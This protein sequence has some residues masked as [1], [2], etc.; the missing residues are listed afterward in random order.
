SPSPY[1]VDDP[2]QTEWRGR[3]LFGSYMVD[4]EGVPAKPPK[5]GDKGPLK[6][7]LL[8]RQP[9]R[10]YEGSNGRARL[11]G[12]FGASTPTISN[13]F[14]STNEYMPTGE[15]KKKMLALIK[16]RN[17]PYGII[18]RKMDFP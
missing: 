9:V 1:V 3:S 17:K 6:T 12:S 15:L 18:V 14:I 2:T 16:T 7:S 8:T 10:G 13:L 11:P 4:R 5:L